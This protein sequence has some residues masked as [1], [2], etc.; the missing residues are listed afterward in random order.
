MT[1]NPVSSRAVQLVDSEVGT[2]QGGV[3][4]TD[5]VEEVHPG[6]R[7]CCKDESEQF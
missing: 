1:Q 5:V 2:V 3:S 7:Q 6:T 4:R